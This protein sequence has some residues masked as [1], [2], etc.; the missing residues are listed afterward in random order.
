[1]EALLDSGRI[2]QN[3]SPDLQSN[4]V[5]AVIGASVAINVLVLAIPF[6]IN[7]VYTSVLPQQSGDSLVVITGMLFAVVLLDLVLKILRSWVLTLLSGAEEQRLRVQAI[8]H[9]LAS[10]LEVARS[11]SLDQRIEQIRA[12]GFLRNRFLQQWIFLRIDL[13]FVALYLLVMAVI[14]GWLALVPIVTAI[15]FYPQAQRA[16]RSATS[17][18]RSRYAKQESR[19]DVLI[20]ALSG[21]ETVKGL[22]IEGFLV[23]RLEPV[24]ESLSS[25][26]YQ[27]QVVNARLQHVGQLYA[28]VTGLMVVTLGSVLVVHH[29]LA[30]GALAACTLLS[31]QVS[32]PF[33]RYFSLVPRFALIDYGVDK[34]N[35]LL[36]LEPEQG[37]YVGNTQELSG[38]VRLGALHMNI[39]ETCVLTGSSPR[40]LSALIAGIL[41][42]RDSSLHPLTIG[43]VN[44]ESLRASERR[45]RL[46]VVPTRPDLFNGTVLDNLTSFRSQTRKDDAIRFCHQLGVHNQLIA[47]PRGY[48]TST[49]EQADFP[50]GADLTFR[51]AVAAALLDQPAL[52]IID[53][54]DCALDVTTLHWIEDLP[55]EVPRLVVLTN[56][57]Y[58]LKRP[59]NVVSLE[60]IQE[61]VSA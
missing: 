12:A 61:G 6:Y 44:V 31:R 33:S 19:D 1:M 26:E 30:T 7:R 48:E 25:T 32:R 10:P 16:A 55:I 17:I 41:G 14:G 43:G 11:Q 2:H 59:M 45:K 37:F 58:A 4:D 5:R 34:I 42:H 40:D 38:G 52:L 51:L 54:S 27:Q 36:T 49:G 50:I 28:Q 39:G 9:Y 35:E 46:R 56:L 21:T 8:R 23:R 60:M 57:P 20:S 53:G 22:G 29:S 13:P 3:W 18:I 24:Q 47:L 15:L